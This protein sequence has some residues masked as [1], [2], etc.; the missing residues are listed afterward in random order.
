MKTP[1]LTSTWRNSKSG[2]ARRWPRLSAEP[3]M[4][5]SRAST[6]NPR[7]SSA[8]HR[9]EPMNPAPP[10][11]TALSLFAANAAV[12]EAQLFH[13]RRIVDVPAVDDDG[14][15]HELLDPGHI[16]LPELVPFGDQDEGVR[17]RGDLVG[18]AHVD[19]AREQDLGPLDRRRVEGSH[20]GACRQEHLRDVH[21]RRVPHVVRVWLERQ[22]EQSDGLA[23]ELLELFAEQ[24]DDH[25]PLIAVDVADGVQELGVVVESLGHRSERRD[26]LAETAPAPADPRVQI[27]RADAPVQSHALGDEL[28]VGADALADPRDLVDERDPGREE[29]VG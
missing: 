24:V 11:T 29:G 14:P 13:G 26:V 9:W 21:A 6:R 7:A 2:L 5:L 22:S 15:A 28:G 23:R 3:V 1:W 17:A 18:V 19:D 10:E 16:E 20:L 8:S 27:G 25:H 4:R 12:R